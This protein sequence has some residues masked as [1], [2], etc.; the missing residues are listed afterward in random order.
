MLLLL[1]LLG[2]RIICSKAG[3]TLLLL[4]L[5]RWLLLGEGIRGL[6]LAAVKLGKG[7]IA[8]VLWRQLLLLGRPPE[9]VPSVALVVVAGC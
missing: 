5:L 8:I 9:G 4:L 1:W 3:N 7:V 6:V 2:K